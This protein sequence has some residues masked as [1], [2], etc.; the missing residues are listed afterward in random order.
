MIEYPIVEEIRQHRKAHMLSNM[1]MILDVLFNLS[2]S[3]NEN[4]I[5]RC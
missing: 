5:V 2:A 3:A 1:E 4:L